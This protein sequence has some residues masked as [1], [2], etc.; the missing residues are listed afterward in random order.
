MFN[1][2]EVAGYPSSKMTDKDYSKTL[3]MVDRIRMRFDHEVAF[4][5]E[6]KF[7]R[8]FGEGDEIRDNE[9]NEIIANSYEDI[10]TLHKKELELLTE[11]QENFDVNNINEILQEYETNIEIIQQTDPNHP[12]DIFNL[13]KRMSIVWKSI[14]QTTKDVNIKALLGQT[15]L[16]VKICYITI[17]LFFHS[18]FQL[19]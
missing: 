1:L 19:Y 14:Q 16:H 15:D 7:Y 13:L 18:K 5:D 3:W 11:L 17:F 9:E 10:I 4:A 6:K 8:Y 2:K 12:V